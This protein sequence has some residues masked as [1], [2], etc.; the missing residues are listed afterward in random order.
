MGF[1]FLEKSA[2]NTFECRNHIEKAHLNRQ[3]EE[4]SQWEAK[5]LE[6]K[7]ARNYGIST[8]IDLNKT[9][10]LEIIEAYRILSIIVA[11]YKNSEQTNKIA[12]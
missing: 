6:T 7:P 3:Q 10:R 4:W 5:I 1:A 9:T 2:W 11:Y 12:V 8:S